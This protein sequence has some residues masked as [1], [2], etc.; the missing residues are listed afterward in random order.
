MWRIGPDHDSGS[1]E[2]PSS[3]SSSVT[4]LRLGRAWKS[5]LRKCSGVA[6]ACQ[7]VLLIA[8]QVAAALSSC[9]LRTRGR[10]LTMRQRAEPPWLSKRRCQIARLPSLAT[11]CQCQEAHRHISV[12]RPHCTPSHHHVGSHP[13]P[14]AIRSGQLERST[15]SV[16]TT[17]S[18][19]C[20]SP[21]ITSSIRQSCLR[22]LAIHRSHASLRSA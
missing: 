8:G 10:I 9:A 3:S 16:R 4:L 13:I 15:F 17:S 6:W 7:R 5:G 18:R 11:P 2:A 14:G 12:S 21:S 22:L 20:A 19:A 1:T